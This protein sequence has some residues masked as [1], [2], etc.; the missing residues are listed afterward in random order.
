VVVN[1]GHPDGSQ[2]LETVIGRTMAEAFSSVLRDPVD[3]TNTLLAGT[4]APAS[5]QRLRAAADRLPG[6]LRPLALRQARVVGPRLP[7]GTV[8]TDDLAPVEWLV[9]RSILGY[10]ASQ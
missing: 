1:V 4:D 5:D 2:E 10:A 3:A 8:Y 9:D 6:P 7:G